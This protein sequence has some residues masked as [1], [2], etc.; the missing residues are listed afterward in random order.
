MKYETA[1]KRAKNK[2]KDI[3]NYIMDLDCDRAI[4]IKKIISLQ[5][6]LCKY[7]INTLDYEIDNIRNLQDSAAQAR[8]TYYSNK[9][10]VTI[11]DET[12]HRH[13]MDMIKLTGWNR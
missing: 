5:D 1:E 9:A 6:Y 7:N 11:K 10:L 13:E 4:L 3:K 2:I 8:A 12:T